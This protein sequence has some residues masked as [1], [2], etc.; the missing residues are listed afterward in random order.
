ML[1]NV[2]AFKN[3]LDLAMLAEKQKLNR[4]RVTA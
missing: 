4:L 1:Y 2:T 3:N